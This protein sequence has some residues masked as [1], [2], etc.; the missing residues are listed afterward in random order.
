[1]RSPER[2][3][4]TKAGPLPLEGVLEVGYVRIAEIR[5]GIG[6]ASVQ[7]PRLSV[8]RSDAAGCEAVLTP[9]V[10]EADGTL[11]EDFSVPP[12]LVPHL[13]QTLYGKY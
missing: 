6:Q 10:R 5:K 8:K 2:E 3:L 11:R 7:H 12:R 9:L 4:P 1:M 13:R